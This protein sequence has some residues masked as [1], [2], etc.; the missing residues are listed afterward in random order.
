MHDIIEK[1]YLGQLPYILAA[2]TLLV[3]TCCLAGAQYF[4]RNSRPTTP[5]EFDA[6]RVVMFETASCPPCDD[7]RKAVGKPHQSSPLSNKVALSYFDV[8]DGQP[9]KRFKISG[10]VDGGTAVVFDVY[11]REA[12]RM[13]IPK[14]L[15]D[16]Q[17][18]LMPHVR[19]AERDLQYSAA[20]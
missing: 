7:F 12:A 19:R 13:G 16:F 11:G 4:A 14:T 9:P 1:K 2:S 10:E 17:S 3:V 15:A 8:T 5:P 6:V 18:N 20:R